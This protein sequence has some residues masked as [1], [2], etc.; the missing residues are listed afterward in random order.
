MAPNDT[1]LNT[2]EYKD[3]IDLTNIKIYLAVFS[4]S[5]LIHYNK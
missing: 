1:N 3:Y 2:F 5:P 4:Q